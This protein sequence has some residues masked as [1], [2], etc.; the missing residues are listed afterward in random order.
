MRHSHCLLI[1]LALIICGCSEKSEPF[2]VDATNDPAQERYDAIDAI[3]MPVLNEAMAANEE[4][5]KLYMAEYKR[6]VSERGEL[7]FE[8]CKEFP[9]SDRA[10]LL[11]DSHWTS[12]MRTNIE[13]GDL[14]SYLKQIKE[15][16]GDDATGE[17]KRHG[18]YWTAFITSFRDVDNGEA[19]LTHAEK[20]SKEF[21]TDQRGVMIYNFATVA[22]DASVPTMSRAFSAI[23]QKYPASQQANRAKAILPLLPNLGLNFEMEFNDAITR[24]KVT[25]ASLRG[26]VVVID[27]WA[28]WC[29]P[30]IDA[31]PYMKQVYA[32][33]EGKGVEFVGISM[34][35]PMAQGGLDNLNQFVK[36]FEVPWPQYYAGED[37]VV[38]QKY[39][40][41]K[42]PTM[43]ILDK[44]G[45]IRSVDGHSVLLRTIDD[46]LKE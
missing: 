3:V 45:V 18:A 31:M 41:D 22:K 11:F 30:C 2:I 33:Y 6:V 42:L 19:I 32:E 27:F 21:S 26:K 40:V 43:F 24:E 14:D 36:D 1:V 16:L 17:L 5:A 29:Q 39:K 20:F 46:L 9:E 23:I 35:L 8:L 12:V 34:D 7:I 38:T 25:M 37:P 28:T 15:V 13:D 10:A 4:Y 44:K